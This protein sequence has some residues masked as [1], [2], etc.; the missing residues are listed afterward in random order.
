MEILSIKGENIASLAKPFEID[1]ENGDLANCGLFAITGNTGA[2]KSSLL[3][4]LCL[5]LYGSCPRLGASGVRDTVPDASGDLIQSDDPR[6]LLRRGATTGHAIVCFRGK[7]GIDY[8]ASWSVR[9]AYGRP[10]GNLQAVD[11]S[12]TRLSDGQVLEN[13]LRRVNERVVELTGL[14]Y[15]EFRRSVL[16]AQ[17]DFD[18]FLSA[19]TSERAAILEK[20]TG[21][22]LYR[23][24]SRRVYS[25]T[26]VA[27]R[28]VEDLTL[29]L[30]EHTILSEERKAEIRER[31]SI[32]AS[33][34]KDTKAA[35]KNIQADLDHYAK[36]ET[37][38]LK[39]AEATSEK[40]ATQNAWQDAEADRAQLARLRKSASV[41]AEFTEER[42]ARASLKQAQET[43]NSLEVDL[44]S[45]VEAEA[46]LRKAR[47]DAQNDV[48]RLEGRFKELGLVWS[49]AERLDANITTA[50][51]ELN[52][53]LA[54]VE[55]C[56][57]QENTLNQTTAEKQATRDRILESM[58][59]FRA[60]INAERAGHVFETQWDIL[61]DRL[62]RRIKCAETKIRTSKQITDIEKEIK[63]KQKRLFEIEKLL[64]EHRANKSR[65][66]LTRKEKESARGTLAERNPAGRLTRLITSEA[67]IRN[68]LQTAQ[69][70][71]SENVKQKTHDEERE[72]TEQYLA[73]SEQDMKSAQSALADA[74]S[75]IR[76]LE[77]PT[78][79][80]EVAI[81][82]EARS[83]RLHL[84]EG[85]PCPV[86]RSTHHPV[87]DDEPTA[88]LARRLRDDLE[89]ARRDRNTQSGIM[90]SKEA[91]IAETKA[92]LRAM[93]VERETLEGSIASLAQ[94][95][96]ETARTEDNGPVAEHVPQSIDGASSLVVV[97]LSAL[98]DRMQQWKSTLAGKRDR[99]DIL[100][101]EI[102][103]LR[104]QI[105]AEE[106]KIG[107][108]REENIE[109][110]DGIAPQ[111]KLL[112]KLNGDRQAAES[113]LRAIDTELDSRLGG[114]VMFKLPGWG[115][116]GAE[117]LTYLEARRTTHMANIEKI[118]N[119]E[120]RLTELREKIGVDEAAKKAAQET[121]RQAEEKERSRRKRLDD[122]H[123]ERGK[124]LDGQPT[125]AH[126]TAFNANRRTAI[127]ERDRIAGEYTEAAQKKSGLEARKQSADMALEAVESRLIR[128]TD[129]L[130]EASARIKIP[131]EELAPLIS[132]EDADIE[133][134]ATTLQVLDTR[135]IQAEKAEE[136]RA[137]DIEELRQSHA[138][139]QTCEE[140][141]ER[142]TQISAQEETLAQEEA[143]LMTELALDNEARQKQTEIV[144]ELEKAK[145]AYDTWVAVN[146][147]VG[148]S[149]G[150]RFS[151][152][153]Q[154]VTLSI[155]VEQANHHLVEIKPR[156]RLALGEGNLSIH[157]VDE[158]MAGEVRSTRSLSGGERFLV[159]LALALAL[160]S[161]GGTGTISNTLFI[162][163]GFGTLD[164]DSLELAID[165]LEALQAQ[166]RTVG[167][168]SHVQAM[169]DRIP[170]QI[171]M[172]A[173]GDGS[174]E[175]VI[176][177]G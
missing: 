99:Q 32:L 44:K 70:H 52:S 106:S 82:A 122:L 80:A 46:Q 69:S 20:V 72:K 103:D 166:G 25:G 15:E 50:E 1:L 5:A 85:E 66:E 101:R 56:R 164:A 98:L 136:T 140:L 42:D 26:Q 3:D 115:S 172:Q 148:S 112:A 59:P 90:V 175:V 131:A 74:E 130:R 63:S 116:F 123:E 51:E 54:D 6:T 165:A 35:L 174:S 160:S 120:T 75:R 91:F 38:K 87:H 64:S 29:K 62:A 9:R 92:R 154:E 142:K 177:A 139:Q 168:I 45:A 153:A 65:F 83:L 151:Q 167:I 33:L 61:H 117:T 124:L 150:D 155:L 129:A 21:T 158:D 28:A 111:E 145:Q 7:D 27:E 132:Y 95:Y 49:E 133:A 24:I 102:E 41:R 141:E 110:S 18:S 109:V 53:A 176:C 88:E 30:G 107:T 162:D 81:S 105:H 127:A 14:T 97:A 104:G 171:Q 169:K 108:L 77:A 23:A 96:A 138:P 58:K 159:S 128:A 17:G 39:L 170:I 31:Q 57:D 34:R 22:V 19:K 36:L 78:E 47:T 121:L 2:G 4:A 125:G 93:T 100:E 173:Q 134:L 68:L 137:R 156:Y 73:Q 161:V 79:M 84:V 143:S 71:V 48:N 16:L 144:I 40:E 10:T 119:A 118:Q 126:R 163:E 60:A 8:E 12:I 76:A 37:A 55:T 43:L 114:P 146:D 152:I 147:A 157:V 149:S 135:K 94:D 89:Q 113:D 13:Q 67:N 11:R 86:C